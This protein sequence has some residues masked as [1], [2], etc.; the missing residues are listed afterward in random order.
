MPALRITNR[1]CCIKRK[2]KKRQTEIMKNIL[3]SARF[4]NLRFRI[5]RP[6]QSCGFNQYSRRNVSKFTH[7]MYHFLEAS[8]KLCHS[9]NMDI[10]LQLLWTECQFIPPCSDRKSQRSWAVLHKADKKSN[11]KFWQPVSQWGHYILNGIYLFKLGDNK[12]FY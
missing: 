12:E 3:R 1:G 11:S 10:F 5:N 8:Y 9:L 4:L 2:Q 6:D 7:I